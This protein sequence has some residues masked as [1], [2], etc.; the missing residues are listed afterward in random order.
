[1]ATL[2]APVRGSGS[3]PAWMARVAKP[4]FAET[5]CL[6]VVFLEVKECVLGNG[7]LAKKIFQNGKALLPGY[8]TPLPQ[9]NEVKDLQ[10]V[11]RQVFE[12]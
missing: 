3:C 1:M 9:S 8:P 7:E 2:T 10:T 6:V 11:G 5:G 4:V 12:E